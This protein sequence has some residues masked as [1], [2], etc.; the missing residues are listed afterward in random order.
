MSN[1]NSVLRVNS[2]NSL[3]IIRRGAWQGDTPGSRRGTVYTVLKRAVRVIF[4]NFFFD[5]L[6]KGSTASW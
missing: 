6:V 5:G 4:L 2:L 3:D 1:D